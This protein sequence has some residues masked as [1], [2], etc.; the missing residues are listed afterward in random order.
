MW[1]RARGND[2]RLIQEMTYWFFP[3]LKHLVAIIKYWEENGIEKIGGF[4]R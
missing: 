4:Q 1:H 3:S 2:K